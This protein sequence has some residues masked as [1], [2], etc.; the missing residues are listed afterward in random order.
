MDWANRNLAVDPWYEARIDNAICLRLYIHN[1]IVDIEV[2]KDDVRSVVV[3]P[4]YSKL[5]L[6][7]PEDGR[8]DLITIFDQLQELRGW[9]WEKFRHCVGLPT[10]QQ[11]I[12]GIKCIL[13]PIAAKYS[14]HIVTD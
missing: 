1:T 8:E 12:E 4:A 3:I 6:A 7:Q 13:E 10:Q 11:T 14:L 2:T 9:Y 5:L